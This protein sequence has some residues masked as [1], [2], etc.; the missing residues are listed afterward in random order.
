M[1]ITKKRV[2]SVKSLRVKLSEKDR[3]LLNAYEL[4][5]LQRDAI[6]KLAVRIY[7]KVAVAR[8]IAGHVGVMN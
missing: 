1:G 3:E 2:V 6:Y 7:G 4:I 5:D 8:A